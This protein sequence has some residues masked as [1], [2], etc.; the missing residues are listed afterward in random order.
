MPRPRRSLQPKEIELH[1]A[2]RLHHLPVELGDGHVRL[3]IAVER[4]QF[5]ERTIADH[6][7]RRMRRRM[8][9]EPFELL[10]YLQQPRHHLIGVARFLQFRL[11]GNRLIERHRIGRIVRHQLAQPIDL[12]VGHL[13]NAAN[14]AQHG[15]RLQL[16]VGDDLRHAV[17]AVLLLYVADHF[18]P[19]VLAEV[20]VEV[21]HRHAFRIKE[22][23]EEQPEPQGVEVGD[24]QRPRDE[25]SG[26]RSAPRPDRDT[27][28]LR[29]LDEVRHDQEV[30]RELHLGDD[31]HLEG[32]PLPVVVF[33]EP[34]RR[35]H[36]REPHPQPLLSLPLQF[37]GLRCQLTRLRR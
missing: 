19:A 12:P 18:F 17:R 35:R 23:L 34:R 37:C 13:E 31:V 7:A 2:R 3:R 20:D 1:E 30:A 29:P 33:A 4:H 9:V 16:A 21:G 28:R 8:P 22:P 11:A 6:D 24:G 10:R 32:E 36:G 27:V 26:P 15:A 14:V 25:R 5:I